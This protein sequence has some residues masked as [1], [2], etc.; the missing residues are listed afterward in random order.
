MDAEAMARQARRRVGMPRLSPDRWGHDKFS[1]L[2][3]E[4]MFEKERAKMEQESQSNPEYSGQEN[5]SKLEGKQM[6]DKEME[7]IEQ[8]VEENAVESKRFVSGVSEDQE[9]VD[10]TDK[11]V[12]E[13]EVGSKTACQYT[14]SK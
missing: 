8:A 4:E 11:M 14:G 5:L 2:E 7:G 13:D 10:M 6:A 3:E 9:M 1:I 12:D